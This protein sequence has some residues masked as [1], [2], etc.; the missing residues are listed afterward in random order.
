V[1]GRGLA[2]SAPPVGRA[3]R[4][5]AHAGNPPPGASAEALQDEEAGLRRIRAEPYAAPTRRVAA[6]RPASSA[7]WTRASGSPRSTCAPTPR[8]PSR[9]TAGSIR[10]EGARRPPPS[11][12]TASPSARVSM[13]VTKPA[14]GAG[15]SATTGAAGRWRSKPSRN[16]AGPPSAA[17]MRSKRSAAA[18]DAKARSSRAAPVAA[19]GTRSGESEEF[20]TE[21]ESSRPRAGRRSRR[22]A[23][24][25]RRPRPRA[26][27]RRP[28]R[29]VRSCR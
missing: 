2:S 11:A 22:R 15:T 7:A 26:R 4:A 12:I 29:A 21:R 8:R 9:P 16:P 10:S 17:T 19:S 25:A 28:M 18:P 13:P 5:G 23:G 20:G 24:S 6:A 27:C 3:P 1:G 14:S